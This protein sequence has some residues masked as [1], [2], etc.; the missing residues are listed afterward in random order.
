MILSSLPTQVA[1]EIPTGD[2][3]VRLSLAQVDLIPASPG[4]CHV[5][6][7]RGLAL[8]YLLLYWSP[9]IGPMNFL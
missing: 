9:L 5:S 2:H 4:S 3:H 6:H 1:S 8:H 7:C